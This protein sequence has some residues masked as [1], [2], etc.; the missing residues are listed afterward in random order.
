V[1]RRLALAAAAALLVA[2]IPAAAKPADELVEIASGKPVTIRADRA[3]LLFRV[4]Q[5]SGVTPLEP[6]LMRVPTAGEI[7]RY[8]AAKA[9]A[10]AK[11]LPGLTKAY[12]AARARNADP[13]PQAP[14]ID[15][16]AFVWDNVANLQDVDFGRTFAKAPEEETFLVEAVPGDYVLYGFTP[17][18]GLPRL[19]VCMCLGTV[20]FSARAGEVTDLGYLV[21]DFAFRASKSPDL[22]GKQGY[23]GTVRAARA[24]SSVPQGLGAARLV[25]AAYR[26]VGRFFT[27]NAVNI[28]RLADVPGVLAYERGTVID[29]PTGKP[30]ADNF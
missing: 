19:M 30:V 27:P 18:T 15:N 9:E 14:S 17:S 10:F 4:T 11:A 5:A 7:A 13:A 26:A 24:D 20:G 6:L 21:S 2:A 23:L 16:F 25:P 29:V 12:E 3:Y 22:L 8:D 28:G 1:T